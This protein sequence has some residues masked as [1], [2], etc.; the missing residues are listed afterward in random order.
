MARCQFGPTVTGLRGKIA[1]VVF[2]QN[3]SGAYA[4]A[5]N[6]P[7]IRRTLPQNVFRG[8]LNDASAAWQTL[9]AGER[10][11]WNDY[12]AAPNEADYDPWGNQ[13]Y[14]SGYYW[15]CRAWQR[16]YWT[17]QGVPSTPPTGPALT[18][19][20]GLSLDLRPYTVGD[21]F[22]SWTAP[23]IP[24]NDYIVFDLAL[25]NNASNAR[26]KSRYLIIGA[27]SDAGTGPQDVTLAIALRWLDITPG[28]RAY[29]RAWYQGEASHRSVVA[30]ADDIIQDV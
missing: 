22:I 16:R 27:Y 14:L 18:A 2:S 4:K 26:P 5:L 28:W 23:S 29:V 19:I 15:F 12:A 9:S 30:E 25:S 7:V 24:A 11:D 13:Y 21:S 20:T 8:R 10:S 1:G 17:G 6:P 3:V